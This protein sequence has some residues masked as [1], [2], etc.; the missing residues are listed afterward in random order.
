MFMKSIFIL[1]TSLIDTLLESRTS[2]HEF[3]CNKVNMYQSHGGSMR[4]IA[5]NCALLDIQVHFASK[6]GNDIHAIEIIKH[7]E[8]QQI[9]VYGPTINK[10]TPIFTNIFDSSRNYLYSTITD[11]FYYHHTD[12]LPTFAFDDVTFA[13]TDNDDESLLKSLLDKIPSRWIMS[14]FIPQEIPLSSL[15]GIILNRHE[16]QPY[17]QG[18]SFDLLSEELTQKGLNWIII[19]LDKEGY[20]YYYNRQGIYVS[21]TTEGGY[22]LGCGD[23]FT[24]GL[25]FGLIQNFPLELALQYAQQAAS[26]VLKEPQT[27]NKNIKELFNNE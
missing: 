1:G 19:T 24:S 8:D 4:N 25:L 3:G 13:I 18:K 22:A 11:E 14:S 7:L 16:V 5:E 15:E 9:Y 21:N 27:I 23:A 10:P 6:F 17:L 12:Y 26:I 20:Y 2:L